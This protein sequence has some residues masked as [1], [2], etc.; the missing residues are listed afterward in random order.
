MCFTFRSS[1][2]TQRPQALQNCLIRTIL[3]RAICGH[4]NQQSWRKDIDRQQDCFKDLVQQRLCNEVLPNAHDSVLR[5]IL[6]L[7]LCWALFCTLR[8][9]FENSKETQGKDAMKNRKEKKTSI[10]D[11][12]LRLFDF[13]NTF[14]IFS[15]L[16]C[17][18]H[19][20]SHEAS[21]AIDE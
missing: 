5:I 14:E 20:C 11:S 21:C 8:G 18:N 4:S 1:L 9:Q 2:E 15:F 13:N 3:K 19:R 17:S 7:I 12:A 10:E 6:P 16:E